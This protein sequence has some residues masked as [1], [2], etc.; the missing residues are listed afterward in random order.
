M[1]DTLP[2]EAGTTRAKKTRKKGSTKMRTRG[3]VLGVA[4]L[5]VVLGAA[6]SFT[7]DAEEGKAPVATFPLSGYQEVPPI[8][9]TMSGTFTASLVGGNTVEYDLTYSGSEG[10]P[11]MAHIHFGTPGVNGGIMAFLCGG[12]GK[13]ACPQSGTV[14]GTIVAADIM[15]IA[16][17]GI[18][19]GDFA[20]FVDAIKNKAAYA[21]VHSS[22]YG[23]GEIRGKLSN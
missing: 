22:V 20:A 9:T 3:F 16:N 5:I 18:V 6:A 1:R 21:N 17:Q 4:A 7:K 12:G 11:T 15:A 19:A 23:G 10:T 2:F 13:P 8:S 14:S